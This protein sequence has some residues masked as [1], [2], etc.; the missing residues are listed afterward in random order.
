M[1]T[2]RKPVK[3]TDLRWVVVRDDG[4]LEPDRSKPVLFL[5]KPSWRPKPTVIRV[6]VTVEEVRR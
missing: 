2:K 3:F 1:A 5:R 4:R 6:R